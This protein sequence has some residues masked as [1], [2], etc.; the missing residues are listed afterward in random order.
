MGKGRQ[1]KTECREYGKPWKGLWT[2]GLYTRPL[3]KYSQRVGQRERCRCS[4]VNV[5]CGVCQGSGGDLANVCRSRRT[6]S[7]STYTD[8][9]SH[10]LYHQKRKRQIF[11]IGRRCWWKEEETRVS[12]EKPQTFTFMNWMQREVRVPWGGIWTRNLVSSMDWIHESSSLCLIHFQFITESFIRL[13][14]C[15]GWGC[16]IS[17]PLSSLLSFFFL[18][19]FFG[20]KL[21]MSTCFLDLTFCLIFSLLLQILWD[22][23]SWCP[24]KNII[25]GTHFYFIL[26][27]FIIN[28]CTVHLRIIHIF[29]CYSIRNSLFL[30]LSLSVARTH[31][32]SLL[33]MIR[34]DLLN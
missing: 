25:N 13:F 34:S 32:H 22:N 18:W 30:S 2:F 33:Q 4:C 20:I 28:L 23:I 5:A 3:G 6:T 17:H 9:L 26:D 10:H 16:R 24:C 11:V 8:L 1:R 27:I 7:T 29:L 15:E 19:F 21:R 12:I 31:T 14:L